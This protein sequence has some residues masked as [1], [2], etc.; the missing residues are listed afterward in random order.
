MG[1]R[2]LKV[3]ATEDLLFAVSIMNK[4]GSGSALVE[5]SGEL[6]GLI[7]EMEIVKFVETSKNP[8]KVTV[9]EIM[10]SLPVRVNEETSVDEA[11]QLMLDSD[12][13]RLPVYRDDILVGMITSTNILAAISKG[14]LAR[15]VFIYL[16]DI[17]KKEASPV[18]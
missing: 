12:T 17:F 16:S 3:Q 13:K 15:E 9:R 18:N 6:T 10:G 11:V 7:T 1:N 14:L 4:A 2:L 5:D 8:S